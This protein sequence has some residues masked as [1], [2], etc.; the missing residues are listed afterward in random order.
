MDG[1]DVQE[2]GAA[3]ASAFRHEALLYEGIDDFVE[4]TSSFIVEGVESGEPVLVVVAA[5][6]IARLREELGARANVVHF[7]DML[8]VGSNPARIIPAWKSFVDGHAG[9]GQPLRGIGEPIWAGRSAE[10]LI[11]CERHEALLNLAFAAPRAWWLLCPYDVGELPRRC[12][13]RRVVTIHSC[14]QRASIRPL[15]SAAP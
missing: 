11:E 13:G 7:A 15:R 6:K 2:T 4:Q 3:P 9:S 1:S 10:E 12:S 14:S 5:E 8:D